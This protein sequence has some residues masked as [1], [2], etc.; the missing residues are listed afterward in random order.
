MHASSRDPMRLELT[1]LITAWLLLLCLAAA[2]FA[3]SYLPLPRGY[4]PLIMLPGVIMIGLVAVR[5]MELTKGII[6]VRAFAVAGI[7][8]LAV[9]LVLGSTDPLTRHNYP[10]PRADVQ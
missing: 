3:A 1:R 5:F 7:F 4:R 10:V 6:L 8:W 9:L 2:E